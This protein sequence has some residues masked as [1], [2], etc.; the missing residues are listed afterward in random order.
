MPSRY[1]DRQ[2]VDPVRIIVIRL[3]EKSSGS[4]CFDVLLTTGLSQTMTV[5]S[6]R[7]EDNNSRRVI[8]L[9]SVAVGLAAPAGGASSAGHPEAFAACGNLVGRGRLASAAT[10]Y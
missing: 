1:G 6:Y 3:C 5:M 7:A 10:A 8:G 9:G 4:S 2:L